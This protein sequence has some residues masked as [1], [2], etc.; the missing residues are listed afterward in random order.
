M[1]MPIYFPHFMSRVWE[2]LEV[3]AGPVVAV[4]MS[5]DTSFFFSVTR[6]I[7]FYPLTLYF[8]RQKDFSA[9]LLSSSEMKIH[10]ESWQFQ[11]FYPAL[12]V[13]V[14]S[15]L[16]PH[17]SSGAHDSFPHVQPACPSLFL[18]PRDFT[19]LSLS[20]FFYSIRAMNDCLKVSLPETERLFIYSHDELEHPAT[21]GTHT[22]SLISR[23]TLCSLSRQFLFLESTQ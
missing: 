22:L 23:L 13:W 4:M 1:M 7:L 8:I 12:F 19:V 10:F 11:T 15:P 6:F 2:R 3:G 17:P 16:F 9:E 5:L 14:S 20:L 18:S 21:L